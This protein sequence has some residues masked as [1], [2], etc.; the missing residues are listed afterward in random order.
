MSKE[1]SRKLE[2]IAQVLSSMGGSSRNQFVSEESGHGK[3]KGRFNLQG[4]L[5]N[6]IKVAALIAFIL[7]V[8][9]FVATIIAK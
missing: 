9:Q 4:F 8:I 6:A 3:K 7:F 2:Q 5:N 1:N